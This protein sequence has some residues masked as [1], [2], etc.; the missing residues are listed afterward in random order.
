MSFLLSEN[1]KLSK[2]I[3]VDL[4]G[5]YSR[6]FRPQIIVGNE[7]PAIPPIF[8]PLAFLRRNEPL[9]A[10]ACFGRFLTGDFKLYRLIELSKCQA[11]DLSSRISNTPAEILK[12]GNQYI[13]I[14]GTGH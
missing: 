13:F 9:G 6:K 8:L 2:T 3:Q 11:N 5:F 7:I 12:C 4:F 10:L 14:T 1:A